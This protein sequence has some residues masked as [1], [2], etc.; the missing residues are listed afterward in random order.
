MLQRSKILV[1]VEKTARI[2]FGAQNYT[3]SIVPGMKDEE[4]CL[5]SKHRRWPSFTGHHSKQRNGVTEV[6]E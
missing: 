5:R 1:A 6:T 3:L 4:S 2:E